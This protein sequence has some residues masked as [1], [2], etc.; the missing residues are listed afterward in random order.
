M[1][2]VDVLER[3]Y[4][5]AEGVTAE[6]NL[7]LLRRLNREFDGDFDLSAFDHRAHYDLA[8]DRIEMHLASRRDQQICVAGRRFSLRRDET[9][10]TEHSHK[11]RPA[12]FATRAA[13]VGWN[14]RRQWQDPQRWFAVLYFE[15]AN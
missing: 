11:F 14:L 4:D 6:F 9:I 1:K 8:R 15:L 5:D 2:P 3:A 10:C 7:N 13:E 12:E